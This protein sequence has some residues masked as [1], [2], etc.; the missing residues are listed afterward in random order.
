MGVFHVFKITLMVPIRATHLIRNLL[1]LMAI[2]PWYIL[3]L[4]YCNKIMNTIL[5]GIVTIDTL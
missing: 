2:F 3:T 1:K 4:Y 5:T